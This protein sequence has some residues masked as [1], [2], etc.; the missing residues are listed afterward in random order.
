VELV[1]ALSEGRYVMDV[2]SN[3]KPEGWEPRR[4]WADMGPWLAG[5]GAATKE[6]RE[7]ERHLRTHLRSLGPIQSVLD[8]GCG[9]GRLASLLAKVLPKA[10]YT[11]IDVGEEQCKATQQVR[12]DGTLYQSA[13]QDFDTRHTYD[14]VLASEVLMHIP[15]N[16]IE[17]AV[18]QLFKLSSKWIVT[19]D[20]TQPLRDE[21]AYWN[22][23]HDYA[24][25]YGDHIVR[26]QKSYA[27]TIYVVHSPG[28]PER[29]PDVG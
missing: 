14:L 12:P 17:Q 13:L 29:V 6:H 28:F 4:Y 25:L 26:S 21:T 20:W 27:Q 22:W 23:R 9:R 24:G 11:G 16:E 3:V 10:H 15:P 19:I 5:P 18:E 2:S 1:H 7:T 8:V